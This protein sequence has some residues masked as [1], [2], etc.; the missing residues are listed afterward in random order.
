MVFFSIDAVWAGLTSLLGTQQAVGVIVIGLVV[1][2]WMARVPVYFVAILLTPV[3]FE[4]VDSGYVPAYVKG[5][6]IVILGVVFGVSF[7]RALAN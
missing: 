6:I 3:L 4:M 7:L 1:L 2:A 5:L